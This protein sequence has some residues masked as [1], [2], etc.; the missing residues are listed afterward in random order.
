MLGCWLSINPDAHSIE[1]L[2]VVRWG[3]LIARK[4]G[5]PK[6]RVLNCLDRAELTNRRF[7]GGE[8]ARR[9]ASR[10]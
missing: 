9:A 4:G 3:I 7:K 1:E 10:R 8:E 5:V 2:S 6:D